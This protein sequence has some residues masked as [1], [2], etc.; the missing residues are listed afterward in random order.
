[1]SRRG[2]V[3][4]KNYV[5]H[6]VNPCP[7]GSSG[8]TLCGRDARKVNCQDPNERVYEGTCKLCAKYRPTT[9]D[10]L[11]EFIRTHHN[12]RQ[13]VSRLLSAPGWSYL[14]VRC[15]LY[16]VS[17]TTINA[18]VFADIRATYPGQGTFTRLVHDL[19]ITYPT[20]PLI[21]EDTH[22]RFRKYLLRHGWQ[23]LY[24]VRAGPIHYTLGIGLD[25]RLCRRIASL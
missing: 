1:M 9:Y 18:F 24:C 25:P 6:I 2:G 14:W 3:H 11:H 20:L 10:R 4:A 19:R 8:Y 15:G 5:T 12:K 17:H 16:R 23:D 22:A 7:A 21:V 13:L